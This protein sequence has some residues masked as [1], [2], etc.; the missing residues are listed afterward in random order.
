MLLR[1]CTIK[2]RTLPY[3]TLDFF[4]M[5]KITLGAVFSQ[6]KTL[7]TNCFNVIVFREMFDITP[8]IYKKCLF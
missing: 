1:L 2:E 6:S 8:Q 7:E 4:K 3:P 5:L